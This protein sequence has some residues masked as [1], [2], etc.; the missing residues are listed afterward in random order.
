MFRA[1]CCV[2]LLGSLFTSSHQC[3]YSFTYVCVRV[4]FVWF[5][6]LRVD[7]DE[8]RVHARIPLPLAFEYTRRP[9]V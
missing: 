1:S 9:K 2:V 5:R 4:M 3:V 6:S 8:N 7:E